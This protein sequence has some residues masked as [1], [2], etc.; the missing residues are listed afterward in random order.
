MSKTMD[1]EE[2][3]DIIGDY[4]REIS[5]ISSGQILS[6]EYTVHPRWL[7][8]NADLWADSSGK[9][10]QSREPIETIEL[11]EINELEWSNQHACENFI[12]LDKDIPVTIEEEVVAS[13]SG[14]GKGA[15]K[16]LQPHPRSLLKKSFLPDEISAENASHEKLQQSPEAHARL[17]SL[18]EASDCDSERVTKT[19][20]PRIMPT[21]PVKMAR[22]ESPK[23][24]RTKGKHSSRP[25]R[26][27]KSDRQDFGENITIIHDVTKGAECQEGWLGRDFN[28]K[29]SR[30][31]IESDEEVDIETEDSP[32]ELQP[33]VPKEETS[34]P[35]E[36]TK[37]PGIQTQRPEVPQ[38]IREILDSVDIPHEEQKII[39]TEVTP[40]EKYFFAEFF[41]GR[42][43]KTPDRFLKIRT[44]I[45]NSWTN[46]KP[47]YVGKTAVRTGLKN[48]GDVNCISRI[49]TFLEQTGVINFGHAG[50]YF[51]YIR[52]LWRLL[53]TFTSVPRKSSAAEGKIIPGKRNRVRHSDGMNVTIQHSE[54]NLMRVSTVPERT[55][56]WKRSR[57]IE[58]VK[59]R[60]F[61]P[62]DVP[63]FSVTVSLSTLLC[64]QLHSLTS[65][66][67][68]MGF[69]GGHW[70]GD[71]I[72]LERYKPC[73]TSKQSGTMCEMCPVSQ[74]EQSD[75]LFMEGFQLLG[76]F[77]SHPL[78]PPNPSRMDIETQA[79]MQRH[80]SADD[81]PFV[82]FILGCVEMNYKCIYIVGGGESPEESVYEI[83]VHVSGDSGALARDLQDILPQFAPLTK[84][85]VE[86]FHASANTLF[87]RQGL[88][89]DIASLLNITDF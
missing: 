86:K 60:K 55:D 87:Q 44:H 36:E 54:E 45:L 79:E 43:T 89:C 48:C 84:E 61:S 76:W 5:N 56:K 2:E 53:D 71:S 6:C 37:F 16:K 24:R 64:L 15:K 30:E 33:S 46:G 65:H 10:S 57:D 42:A 50:E 88:S 13:S 18:S 25:P 14:A 74:V 49:H 66:H 69:L 17:R 35:R 28:V 39:P 21:I 20:S 4:E 85:T 77:H 11:A 82:G 67:E 75:C 81:A 68:V 47:V 78:F 63:P 7:T 8:D 51:H 31:E 3:I 83:D 72:F 34:V 32:A 58:L 41:D 38:N 80:F 12:V 23:K 19:T 73:R 1:E 9:E 70:H 52:P 27:K 26:H 40:V 29:I 62:T 59:C 22:R